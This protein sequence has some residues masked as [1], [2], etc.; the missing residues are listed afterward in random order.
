MELGELWQDRKWFIVP[1]M[2]QDQSAVGS[3]VQ[4]AMSLMFIMRVLDATSGLGWAERH[5]FNKLV[6]E[7]LPAVAGILRNWMAKNGD[8]G[9]RSMQVK[10]NP[11]HLSRL[12]PSLL[13]KVISI[14]ERY[15]LLDDVFDPSQ[16]MGFPELED[17]IKLEDMIKKLYGKKTNT[18]GHK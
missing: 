5:G 7:Q 4:V 17:T 11:M 16:R 15:G 6:D 8:V 14:K 3:A 13:R 2:G 12:D 9:M 18:N 10:E 1:Q